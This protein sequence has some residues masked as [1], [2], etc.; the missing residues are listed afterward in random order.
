MNELIVSNANT[1]NSQTLLQMV[2]EAR[3]LC[4]EPEVR[5]NKFIEK[6]LDEL[7]GEDGYT[8][9]ATVPPGGGTPMTVI[10]MTYK[11]AM[12]VAAR[13]SK[14]VRRSLIDQLEE[15]QQKALA[16]PQQQTQLI[17]G[18]P[19]HFNKCFTECFTQAYSTYF[20]KPAQT[21]LTDQQQHT[22]PVEEV[23][24]KTLPPDY[25]YKHHPDNEIC[26]SEMEP[27]I[28][29]LNLRKELIAIFEFNGREHKPGSRKDKGNIFKAKPY[30]VYKKADVLP[31]L[32]AAQRWKL[33]NG[34]EKLLGRDFSFKEEIAATDYQ[35]EKFDDAY[36]KLQDLNDKY[37]KDK[38][39]KKRAKKQAK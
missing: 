31:V 33:N 32:K 21:A 5:N 1:I 4:G 12:R 24:D 35:G 15:L 27:Y 22:E 17:P 2:N 36:N 16:A 6:I 11:Q 38:Q 3:K 8:K 7:D 34:G 29:N 30:T 25:T 9:S 23:E 14:A 13:E 37:L 28:S 19:E 26:L 39:D 10:T 20:G 18:T